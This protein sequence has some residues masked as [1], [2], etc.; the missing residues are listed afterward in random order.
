LKKIY[1]YFCF[2]VGLRVTCFS[3]LR[4]TLTQLIV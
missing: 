4:G 3:S 1:G 2:F